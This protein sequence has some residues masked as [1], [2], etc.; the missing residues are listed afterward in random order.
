M[1]RRRPAGAP[2]DT[3]A[4][5][6]QR[7]NERLRE[8]LAA[9]SA[10]GVVRAGWLSKHRPHVAS[11]LWAALWEPRYVVLRG[12]E[13]LLYR[14][15]ADVGLPPR[16]AVDLR[17]TTVLTEGLKRRR[18]HTF[19]LLDANGAALVRLSTEVASE[20]AA[21]VE[22]LERAG[23]ALRGASPSQSGASGGFGAA[24]GGGA[25]R[26]EEADSGGAAAR[27]RLRVRAGSGRGGTDADTDTDA[28]SSDAPARHARR[29]AP[30]RRRAAAAYAPVHLAPAA[31]ILSSERISFIEQR[32]LI[33]LV[34]IALAATNARLVLE[35][36]IKYGLRFNPLTFLRAALTPAPNAGALLLCWPAMAA[37]VAAALLIE[38]AGAAALRR[39]RAA[40]RRAKD[41]RAPHFEVRR[42]KARAAR[43]TEAWVVAAEVAN[44]A[45]AAAVPYAICWR[46]S[47]GAE[48]L[49]AG[50]ITAAATILHLKLWSF[51]H[52]NAALRRAHRAGG[53]GPCA[54][55]EAGFGGE[56]EGVETGAVWPAN[57]TARGLAYFL[58]AP[59]L[60]YQLAY[61]R[62]PRIRAR[63]TARRLLQLALALGAMLFI[64]EQYIE[65]TIDNS[66]RPL[67]EMDALRLLE[68]VLKLSLPV[69]YFWLAMFYALFHLWLNV[70][71]ELT[72]FGDREFYRAW[73]NA[74]TVGEYWR[75]WNMPVHRWMVRH[76]YLPLIRR[77]APPFWAGVAV[78]AV[79]A[80]FHEA[81]VAV[82]LK[83]LR[84]WAFAGIMGQVP[85]MWATEALKRR[86]GSEWVGNAVFWVS[87]CFL[88]QPIAEMLY[89]H[90]W[91]KAHRGL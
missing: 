70:V 52:A 23:C 82:P 90:D 6:L 45:A 60:C 55:G 1:L 77:G 57:L 46:T 66:L 34:L 49:P 12:R 38:R 37:T 4:A 29:A 86:S 7:E 68:R 72:R 21:W 67:R 48:P 51:A 64:Q 80:F 20:A 63:W 65:P 75:L 33:T 56:A 32:G 78:F 54:A 53:A 35:N 89:Y 84:G 25:D 87:F 81:L 5:A 74:T 91:R 69:L 9:R 44:V 16:R 83:S 31:S 40:A 14:S 27:A 88:G 71:A 10:A 85:L 76:V 61:P 73:W 58:A 62:S 79:S 59:T 50:A 30:E 28:S 2:A 24:A 19:T 41:A 15:E 13:L 22:A 18:H 47:S 43:V 3:D 26:G 8:L 36:A 39:E 17:S 42:L 11:S